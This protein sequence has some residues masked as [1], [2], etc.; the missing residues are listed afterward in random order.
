MLRKKILVLSAL[1]VA[2]VLATAG[3]AGGSSPTT[4]SGKPLRVAVLAASSQNGFNQAVY[5]G[6]QD[7][8]KKLGIQIEAKLLDGQFDSNTQ[9]SQMQ[10][11]TSSGQYDG[12]IV[13][14]HDGPSLA[15]AF[16]TANKMPVVTAL[17][18]IGP[19][20][21]KMEPQVEGVVSTI[22]IPPS[23]AAKLQAEHVVDYCKDINPCK[24]ALMVGYLSSPLDVARRDAY[25]A[26]LKPNSNIQIVATLEGNWDRDKSLTA[27]ANMLQSNK[28]VNAILS[29]GD[30]MT[31][32]AQIALTAA[33]IDPASIYLTGFGGTTDAVKAVR[34]G[35]WK[36]TYLN[37]PVSMG[38]AA[39]EQLN[40][41]ITEKPVK[42]VINM[43][44]IGGIDPYAT[45]ESL[46]KTPDF[47]GEWNG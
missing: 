1:S 22:A 15:A 35:I 3:C 14:P 25:Q 28:D 16:P 33:G 12:V 39:I 37:F 27:V 34:D 9:L 17:N 19:D 21:N 8:A 47:K 13:V 40:N 46:S 45:K 36:S 18:P 31:S 41:A 29:G 30:Q 43:L 24:V 10:N 32:G 7:G 26:V 23:D 4:T 44:D 42:S 5:K 20:I 38:S 11:V 6:V 2:T